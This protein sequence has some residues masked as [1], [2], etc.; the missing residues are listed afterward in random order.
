MRPSISKRMWTQPD[1]PMAAPFCRMSF[2]LFRT[3]GDV[4]RIIA[5]RTPDREMLGIGQRIQDQLALCPDALAYMTRPYGGEAPLFVLART[6]I[7]VLSSRYRLAAGLGLY[8]HIHTKPDAAARLI[9]RGVLGTP[10]GTAFSVTEEIRQMGDTV[11]ARDEP[12]YSPLLEAWE[13]VR[14]GKDGVFTVDGA[15][16][17]P[18]YRLREGIAKLA[19]FVGCG[20]TFTLPKETR[21][22]GDPR[23]ASVRC[24]RP[25]AFEAVLLCLLA[26]VR[27][28]SATHCGVCRLDPYP[29]GREGLA[30]TLRYPLYP[31]ETPDGAD[32]ARGV[33]DYLTAVGETWGLDLYAPVR[34]TPSHEAEGLSDV[35][36]ALD[37]LL[38]PA[39]L[40]TSDIKARLALARD[41]SDREAEPIGVEEI[42]WDDGF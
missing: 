12:S 2:A 39:V 4:G 24:Y 30:L 6:G 16:S 5:A 18:L 34:L 33:H 8:L 28:R 35:T 14:L 9:N 31:H 29:H 3:G 32:F 42:P 41:R 37:W 11:T 22:Q 20:L 36:V 10:D 25:A 1:L 26:E 38:D 23:G 40:A 7:G 17:L 21:G 27:E 13:A 19:D 15:G